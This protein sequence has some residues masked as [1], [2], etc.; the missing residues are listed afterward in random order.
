MLVILT[1]LF[2]VFLF[3]GLGVLLRRLKFAK[4]ENGVFLLK[5]IFF[6]ALPSLILVKISH[7]TISPDKYYLPLIG[8]LVNLGCLAFTFTF[9]RFMNL[10]KKTLG[11]MFVC[12]S[13]VNNMFLYPF[14]LY[15]MGDEAFSDLVILDLGNGI[16]TATLVYGI[17]LAY[18]EDKVSASKIMFKLFSSPIIWALAIAV[19]L[20][21]YAIPLPEMVESFLHPLGE[22]ASPLI[23]ISLGIF[24]APKMK[25]LG[26]VSF[27]IFARS[28]VGL[29]IGLLLA[30]MFGFGGLSFAV[31][32][33][34]AAAPIGFT[35]LAFSSIGKLDTQFTSRAVSLS[36]LLGML[37]IPLMM[38]FFSF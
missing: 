12:T 29:L 25:N 33:I 11:S 24:F 36:I 30:W 15:G 21:S 31:I 19:I 4:L 1:K 10:D 5:F 6:I 16:T 32:A 8:I 3:F 2:P 18:G 14:V 17:A 26:L 34:S 28:V 27:V 20:S 37:Y 9:S 23:L 7:I 38:I 22:M 35:A 13:V